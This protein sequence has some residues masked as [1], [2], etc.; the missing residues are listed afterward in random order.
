LLRLAAALAPLQLG[1]PLKLPEARS[2]AD[3][4]RHEFVVELPPVDVPPATLGG[5]DAMVMLPLCR[6]V[7]PVSGAMY[8]YHI[9]I[10]DAAGQRLPQTLLHH[11][12]L[13]DPDHRELFLPIGQH[14][15]AAS[16][17]TPAPMI[18]PLLFG[19]PL[20]RGQR[21]MVG[22]MLA[23]STPV[24][25]RG[26]RV[27]VV[28]RY[29]PTGRPWP[30]F[31]VY[32]WVM[33]VQFPLGRPGG[34]SKAFDLPPGRTVRSWDSSP[35]VAGTI[36]GVGGHLHDYGVSLEL[37]DLTSGEVIWHATPLTDGHGRVLSLPLAR[38]YRWY[39]LGVHITPAHRYRV[40]AVYDN[41]TGHVI[42]DGGMGAVAGLFVPDRGTVWPAVD[43]S[44]TVYQQDLEDTLISGRSNG[45]MMMMMEHSAR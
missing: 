15:L 7:V 35:A 23:N 24:A 30:L 39:R 16:K 5:P 28:L 8:A 43:R 38:L 3:T 11:L 4:D 41:P 26:V 20:E 34:G 17:E 14:L 19:M 25:E 44:N 31:R 22:A 2:T 32:P 6:V 18:P 45:M 29:V 37:T 40:A 13:S 1:A 10:L 27:R 42:H 21:L 36:M 33:D 12:N 9:E